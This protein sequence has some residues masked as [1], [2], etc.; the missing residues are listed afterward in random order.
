MTQISR[1]IASEKYMF[2]PMSALLLDANAIENNLID[3]V[4]NPVIRD[5]ENK[6]VT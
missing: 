1:I 6:T 5:S 4:N 2:L 3:Q